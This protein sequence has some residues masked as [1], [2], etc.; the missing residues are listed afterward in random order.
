MMDF[1][2]IPDASRG[3]CAPEGGLAGLIFDVARTR[4]SLP[5]SISHIYVVEPG[6]QK[7]SK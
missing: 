5:F 2:T 1:G 4:S 3:A 6:N 7:I